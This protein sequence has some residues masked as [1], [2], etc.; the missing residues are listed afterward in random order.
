MTVEEYAAKAG[1]KISE[2]PADE[3]Y[4]QEL[5]KILSEKSFSGASMQLAY[6]VPRMTPDGTCSMP[7]D[8]DP[9]PYD[10][11]ATLRANGFSNERIHDFVAKADALVELLHR[12]TGADWTGIYY[13]L[14]VSGGEA[15]VKIAYRGRPSRAEFPLTAEFAAHSN[16]STVGLSGKAVL[17][18]SVAVHVAD[19]NPYYECDGAVQSELC[20]PFFSEEGEVAGIIDLESFAEK[21]FTHEINT[22]VALLCSQLF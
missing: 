4:T 10:L 1:I 11:A 16:N 15:L 20:A 12:V 13:R 6:Q 14:K 17:V 21:H 19:G 5:G 8:L 18:E 2:T 3:A 9:V 7:D 22:K